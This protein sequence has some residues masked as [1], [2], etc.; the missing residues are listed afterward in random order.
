M[1]QPRP[2]CRGFAFDR[3]F[4][5][6]YHMSWFEPP[7]LAK[8]PQRP[9]LLAGLSSTQRARVRQFLILGALIG[10]LVGAGLGGAVA[11]AVGTIPWMSGVPSSVFIICFGLLGSLS[12]VALTARVLLLAI[13]FGRKESPQP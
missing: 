5:H 9:K 6:T 10:G 2:E 11:W 4:R 13:A 12:V 3:L 8:K 1:T 7:P